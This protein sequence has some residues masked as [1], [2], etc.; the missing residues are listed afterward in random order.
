M[1]ELNPAYLVNTLS[2]RDD[3]HIVLA[4]SGGLDSMV[5]LDLLAKARQQLPF[6]LQAVYVHHGISQHASAW[7][8]FCARQCALR[9]IDFSKREVTLAGTDN[10][11][12]KARVARYQV[13]ADFIQSQQHMLLTAHHSDDQLETLLLA[14]KRG[15]GSA[16]LRGIA[17]QRPFAAGQLCRP[18]LAFSRAELAQ[19]ASAQ[20][21]KWVEDDSNS[22]TRF[23]RNFIRQQIAPLLRQRWP[24]F[25]EAAQRS[26][27]HLFAQQQLLDHYTQQA[28]QQC[29][30]GKSL[31]LKQ[32]EQYHP[33][34]QDLVI[35]AWLAQFGLNPQTQWLTTLKQQVIAARQD[36]SPQLL[37]GNYQ[38][39]RF[40]DA[41]Y[42][43]SSADITEPKVQLHWQGE[44]K[45]H[46]PAGL[47]CVVFA[48]TADHRAQALA[49]SDAEIVFGQL[50]LRFT[51]LGQSMS[52][53][54]KQ[55]FK[56]W[57]VPPW[58]RQRIPLLL[59]GGQLQVVLGYASSVSPAQ[60]TH[61]VRWQQA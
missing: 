49:G 9:G 10:L 15:S 32:L 50:S 24:H 52:K 57:R 28:M 3:S 39:R 37:L 51:P 43:L 17:F 59:V 53:P 38:L 27:Q 12:S 11:E 16:G 23:E 18:L 14:L 36:A 54:L 33:L 30:A 56:L 6:A 26:M 19:Y 2:L 48:T 34:Q 1:P 45:L 44:A 20:Q 40:A 22:D 8:E 7:G 31:S 35:R 41:L 42:L 4:L 61:F 25:A 21:L 46:L 13:L 55:W 5:L 47:G 58:Q 60:A 29:V